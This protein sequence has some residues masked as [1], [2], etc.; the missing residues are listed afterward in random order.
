MS[1]KNN[2]FSIEN[3]LE[4]LEENKG[5]LI[6]I[7]CGA[8]FVAICANAVILSN[9]LGLK[10]ICIKQGVCKVGIPVNSIYDYIK[11]LERIGD[12]FVIYNYS[13]DEMIEN[14][15]R[16]AESS[17]EITQF[18][19]FFN[20]WFLRDTSKKIKNGKKTRAKEGKVMTMYPTYR[21]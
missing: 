12:S 17:E 14:G 16:Y 1:N 7:R 8:F 2:F 3:N 6:W 13:K 18:K 11:K 9:I 15:E 10:R 20:E 19:A 21:I 5:Y 4:N